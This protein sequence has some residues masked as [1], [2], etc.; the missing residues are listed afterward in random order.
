[1]LRNQ[2]TLQDEAPAA[3]AQ[4]LEL[5]VLLPDMQIMRRQRVVYV[6]GTAGGP[7]SIHRTLGEAIL[8]TLETHGPNF[9][10]AYVASE[11]RIAHIV[12]SAQLHHEGNHH[13]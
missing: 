5:P 13:G 1:M 6:Y 11:R 7:P 10:L 9:A 4:R 8:D 3:L 12:L 2:P